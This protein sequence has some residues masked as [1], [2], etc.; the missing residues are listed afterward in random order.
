MVIETREYKLDKRTF[1]RASYRVYWSRLRWITL[2][3]LVVAFLLYLVDMPWLGLLEFIL[4]FA[5]PV[6][7][8]FIRAKRA[9]ALPLNDL[10]YVMRFSESELEQLSGGERRTLILYTELAS[11]NVIPE[12]ICIWVG[13]KGPWA[14]IER[15]AFKSSADFDASCALLTQAGLIRT[16]SRFKP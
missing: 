3:S 14:L 12:G 4:A 7:I 1:M 16:K 9:L 8:A 11:A 13:P 2:V 10:A 5:M 6:I 15:A